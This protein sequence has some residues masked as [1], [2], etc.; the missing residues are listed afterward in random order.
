VSN[1]AALWALFFALALAVLLLDLRLSGG[2]TQHTSFRRA[3]IRLG[4]WLLLAFLCALLMGGVYGVSSGKRFG[5]CYLKSLSI[6]HVLVFAALFRHFAVPLGA[7]HRILFWGAII[8]VAL[9]V[10]LVFINLAM[11]A[12][13]HWMVH[14]FGAALVVVGIKIL[15]RCREAPIQDAAG[16]WS[17][18]VMRRLLPLSSSC[19]GPYFVVREGGRWRATPL[20]LVLLSLELCD[21]CYALDEIPA[22]LA[23]SRE[24]FT[25]V[26]ANTLAAM[27]LRA[28]YL[29][30]APYAM[31]WVRVRAATGLLLV[32]S[33][34][35]LLTKD[36]IVVP[37]V[38]TLAVIAAVMTAAI[39]WSLRTRRGSAE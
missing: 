28:L 33:G 2:D 11:L 4:V 38:V 13:A 19:Q 24:A 10:K 31:H 25:V 20:L 15:R 3:L 30:I 18:R 8:N 7:Q 17:V 1:N 26:S 12:A 9:R 36:V 22:M 35:K 5:A 34:I 23:I 27:T 32:F 16:L 14:L 29:A 21:I 39:L 6:D 37:D